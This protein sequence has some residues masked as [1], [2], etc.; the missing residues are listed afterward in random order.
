MRDWRTAVER[1]G[2]TFYSPRCRALAQSLT[3]ADRGLLLSG[4]DAVPER[5]SRHN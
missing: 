5:S 4:S 2:V 1:R 3:N